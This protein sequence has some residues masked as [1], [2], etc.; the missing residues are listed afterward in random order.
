[1]A[2]VGL[3][4]ASLIGGLASA[5][6]SIFSGILGSNAAEQAAQEQAQTA[7]EGIN[8]EQ[9]EFTTQQANQAPYLQAGDQSLASLLQGLNSGQFG[10]ASTGKAPAAP[11]PF[12]GTFQAPTAAQ[13]AAT[14]GEQFEQQ[15]GNLGILEGSAAAGGAISGGTLKSLADYDTGLASSTYGNVFNQALQTYGAGVTGYQTN[16]QD[17]ASQLAG[18][19]TQLGAQQQGYNQL[20]APASLG[21]QATSSAN[22]SG[23]QT[24]NSIAQLLA[25][26]GNSQAAGTIGS[27]N[28]ITSGLSGGANSL[29]STLLLSQLLGNQ[30]NQAAT[31]Q[32]APQAAPATVPTL[33]SGTIGT[34]SQSYSNL[35]NNSFV[36]ALGG[37]P[38]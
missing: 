35:L 27:T 3:G 37:G 9:Q 18:Y 12:T 34:N 7:Q 21:E 22:A 31:P 8:L 14:P 16:L 24:T 20:L 33:P 10:P 2:S 19:Q 17:Y 1:M 11:A 28:A 25:S 38:G 6:G 4:T 23:A 32:V 30:T 26:L 36:A 15:Q 29:S 5:G 13:A